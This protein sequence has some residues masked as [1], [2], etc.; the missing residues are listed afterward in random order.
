MGGISIGPL[1]LPSRSTLLLFLS[2][3]ASGLTK[4]QT[5]K[6]SKNRYLNATSRETIAYIVNNLD[7]YARFLPF[8]P[9]QK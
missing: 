1:S 6:A 2:S 8:F 4:H 5:S 7:F 9:P 3:I